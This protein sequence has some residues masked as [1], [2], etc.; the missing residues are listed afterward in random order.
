MTLRTLI[1]LGLAIAAAIGFIEI[2]EEVIEG[3]ADAWDIPVGH[4]IRSSL[5]SRAADWFFGTVTHAGGWTMIIAATAATA[6]FAIARGHRWT[7]AIVAANTIAT[8]VLNTLLKELFGRDRPDL[9]PA[10]AL[11]ASY[12]FPSGHSMVS[13]AVYGAI[14]AVI[15]RVAPRARVPTIVGAVLLVAAIGLS[16]VY[17]GV[18]WPL[19][20]LAGYAAAIPLVAVTAHLVR[21]LDPL[22]SRNGG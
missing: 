4:A 1:G 18:H 7:A 20:V 6:L 16:R 15:A 21:R 11:P 9:S 3:N 17:L 10:I 8:E 14:A 13:F 12:S 19:D 5:A 2:A 22:P